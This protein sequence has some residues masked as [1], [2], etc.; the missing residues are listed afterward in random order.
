MPWEMDWLVDWPTVEAV[1][2][3]SEVAAAWEA[4]T[5]C[6][7]DTACDSADEPPRL[8]PEDTPV[9][10]LSL[11]PEDTPVVWVLPAVNDDPK[12]LEDDTVLVS[13]VPAAEV[14]D[15]ETPNPPDTPEVSVRDAPEAAESPRVLVPV[16]LWESWS[17]RLCETP[18]DDPVVADELISVEFD[19]FAPLLAVSVTPWELPTL[20]EFDSDWP[21]DNPSV[22]DVDWLVD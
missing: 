17:D 9:D 7:A 2:W 10:K 5:D 13:D 20:T 19:Q 18:W 4:V 3:V 6:D 14:F 1:D 16:T 11:T 22:C 21:T 8:A 12:A 15:P